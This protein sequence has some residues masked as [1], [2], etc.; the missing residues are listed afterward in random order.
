MTRLVP[1]SHTYPKLLEIYSITRILP[2]TVSTHI[3]VNKYIKPQN[4]IMPVLLLYIRISK[5]IANKAIEKPCTEPSIMI[6]NRL[7]LLFCCSGS[8]VSSNGLLYLAIEMIGPMRPAT[9]TNAL[10][11]VLMVSCAS[12]VTIL[13][14]I[15]CPMR[16]SPV[17]S[18]PHIKGGKKQRETARISHRYI[19]LFDPLIF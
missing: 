16:R 19:A 15:F 2:N 13:F 5:T 11:A 18:K 10:Q 1:K 6:K 12:M 8:A 3:P 4:I 17:C 14:I 9:A 7:S